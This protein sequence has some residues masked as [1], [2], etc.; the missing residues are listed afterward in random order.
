MSTVK[1]LRQ[2]HNRLDIQRVVV[3]VM[4]ACRRWRAMRR[5]CPPPSAEDTARA[6]TCAYRAAAFALMQEAH[7][8]Y[9]VCHRG[10]RAAPMCCYRLWCGCLLASRTV[11]QWLEANLVVA[12]V[13][14]WMWLFPFCIVRMLV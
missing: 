12:G 3:L 6:A 1:R 4:S 8:N 11:H 2:R 14:R 7:I 9:A 10:V 5:A 13:S